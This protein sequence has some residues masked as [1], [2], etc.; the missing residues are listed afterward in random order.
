[1]SQSSSSP[2]SEL[3]PSAVDQRQL[4]RFFLFGFYCALIPSE[5][6]TAALLTYSLCSDA[7]VGAIVLGAYIYRI[8]P[9]QGS[10]R[11]GHLRLFPPY[12]SIGLRRRPC[13]DRPLAAGLFRRRRARRFPCISA[14]PGKRVLYL[15]LFFF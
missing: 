11:H 5:N 7:P 2:P 6:E 1:M 10:D 3:E 14:T 8:W 13:I 4:P 9:P 15:D 12:A